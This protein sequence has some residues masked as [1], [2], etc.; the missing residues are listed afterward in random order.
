MIRGPY[1]S[2]TM[3][4]TVAERHDWWKQHG[5]EAST[6]RTDSK[7]GVPAWFRGTAHAGSRPRKVE[8][9]QPMPAHELR[10]ERREELRKAIRGWTFG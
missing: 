7:E 8:Y 2:L 9:V 6:K 4:M 5:R 10:K 1:T 3:H